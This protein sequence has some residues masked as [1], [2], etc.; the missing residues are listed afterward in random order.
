MRS[1]W[2]VSVPS[3]AALLRHRCLCPS[4]T[5]PPWVGDGHKQVGP[6]RRGDDYAGLLCRCAHLSPRQVG[7]FPRQRDFPLRV[8]RLRV[9]CARRGRG[10]LRERSAHA[11][12]PAGARTPPVVPRTAA[13]RA[14]SAGRPDSPAS[15]PEGKRDSGGLPGTFRMASSPWPRQTRPGPP[16]AQNWGGGARSGA[17]PFAPDVPDGAA[18]SLCVIGSDWPLQ[19]R[20]CRRTLVRPGRLG[21][22]A[23]GR[24]PDSGVHSLRLH[25]L[26]VHSLRVHNGRSP[27]VTAVAGSADRQSHPRRRQ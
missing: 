7:A 12:H 14:S 23:A 27:S 6:R 4:P 17:G 24:R 19:S 20:M 9:R 21:V 11:P 25:S 10:S 1:S 3:S 13:V 22:T 16:D 8:T 26:R 5:R 2:R 18:S 15:L